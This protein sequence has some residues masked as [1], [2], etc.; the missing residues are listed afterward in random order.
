M[1]KITFEDY[2]STNTPINASNLNAIQT[3]VENAIED[4]S[5]YSQT[6]TLIGE[7]LG[8]PLYRKV[9]TYSKTTEG[10]TVTIPMGISGYDKVWVNY[11]KSASWLY[12]YTLS[13][14]INQY[15]GEN[16]WSKAYISAGNVVILLGND[17]NSVNMDFIVTIEYTKSV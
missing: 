1:Q 9:L 3:N 14:G 8:Q 11:G 7:F 15:S 13:L 10:T 2:P 16:D 5:T 17:Y 4:L 12:N 6:E